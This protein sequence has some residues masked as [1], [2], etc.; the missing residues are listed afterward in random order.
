MKL[1]DYVAQRIADHGITQVFMMTGGGAMLTPFGA[2]LLERYQRIQAAAS[3]AAADD[4]AALTRA[5]L[6]D[7]GPKI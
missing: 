1:S 3:A 6:P 5:A 7:A 4:M 2:E